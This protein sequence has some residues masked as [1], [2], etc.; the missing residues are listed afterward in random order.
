M[1]HTPP[2]PVCRQLTF[3]PSDNSD[4]SED[5]QPTPRV[6]PADA[7]VYLDEEEE[8]FQMVPVDDEHWTTEEVPD[9]TLYNTNMPYHMDYGHI[10][11]LMWITYFLPTL[12]LWI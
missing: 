11:V 4:I 10:C 5:T 1:F 8:D 9:R 7:Q 12:T 3:S 6:S 2:R